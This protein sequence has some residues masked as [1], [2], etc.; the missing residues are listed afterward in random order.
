[1][2]IEQKTITPKMAAEMLRDN[3]YNRNITT[4]HVN[5]LAEEMKKGNWK[6]NGDTIR[7]AK[8]R[9][10]DGQ[11]RLEACIKAGASFP[12]IIIYDLPDDVFDTIDIGKA[13][14]GADTLSTLGEKNTRIVAA[15]LRNLKNMASADDETLP[16]EKMTNSELVG[17]LALHPKIRN[18]ATLITGKPIVRGLIPPGWAVALHYLF[19]Q[20]EP[21]MADL[22]FDAIETG[23]NLSPTD[24]LYHLRQRLTTNRLTT[25]KLPVPHIV[26]L[27]IKAW[28]ACLAGE[29][30]R[31]L[32]WSSVEGFP[33]LPV[34]ADG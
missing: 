19:A 32:R 33:K 9:L 27:M 25:A 4:R 3:K 10:I 7:F 24:P 2:R 26:A 34:R 31:V 21:A 15:A 30:M 18:S 16:D 8:G 1:M 22:F 11:H 13:R 12:A 23:T 17:L 6:L 29:K 20:K 5:R 14:S 28:K